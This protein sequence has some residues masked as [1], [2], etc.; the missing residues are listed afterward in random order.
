MHSARFSTPGPSPSPQPWWTRYREEPYLSTLP[1]DGARTR[2]TRVVERVATQTVPAQTILNALPYELRVYEYGGRYN[3][4]ALIPSRLVDDEVLRINAPPG[5]NVHLAPG[6][7]Y[8]HA[9]LSRFLDGRVYQ[10]TSMCLM[11]GMPNPPHAV[12]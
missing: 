11:P 2:F 1:L 6:E 4:T 9:S 5:L 10:L 7:T 3:I 12:S 8:T